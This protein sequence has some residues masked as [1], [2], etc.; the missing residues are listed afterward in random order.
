MRY[1]REELGEFCTAYIENR[2]GRHTFVTMTSTGIKREGER[3]AGY[4]VAQE[5]AEDAFDRQVLDY[6][7]DKP[8][9][10]CWRMPKT[11]VE[12]SVVRLN[13]WTGKDGP[14]VEPEILRLGYVIGR[15]C[16][17][18]DTASIKSIEAMNADI[19]RRN[20]ESNA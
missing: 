18:E 20:A 7:K 9:T 14:S 16:V 12:E 15:L 4:F 10:I 3:V 19:D 17:V 8:G 6:I 13:V 5:L 1:E 2:D 11:Y